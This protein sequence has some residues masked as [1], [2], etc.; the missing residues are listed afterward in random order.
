MAVN[1]AK[2]GG[3][4]A[5]SPENID[6][7]APLFS[8]PLPEKTRPVKEKIDYVALRAEYQQLLSDGTCG[9]K[10]EVARHLGFSRVWVC[11]VLKGIKR[12]PD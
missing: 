12:K 9:T 5:L 7:L 1:V 2:L 3:F 4:L 6:H 8:G 10:A 11:R